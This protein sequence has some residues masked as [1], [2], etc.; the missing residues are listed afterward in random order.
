MMEETQAFENRV[1]ESLNAAKTVRSFMLKAVER[2]SCWLK[3]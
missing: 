1:L 2:L 3:P